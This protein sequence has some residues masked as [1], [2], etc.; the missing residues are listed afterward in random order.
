MQFTAGEI[1]EIVNGELEGDPNVIITGPSKIEEGTAG[2]ISFLANPKYE[3]YIYSSDVAALLVPRD[4][5]PK[6][7]ISATL[8]K[9]KD[10]YGAVAM[11]FEEFQKLNKPF[12]RSKK[13]HISD[14]ASIHDSVSIDA[15][16]FVDSNVT[17][18][19]NTSLYPQVYLGKN[20][21]IGKNCTL[22]PGVKV[23]ANSVIGDNVI[24]HSN[25][26]IGGDG[27]GY[28]RESSGSY[29][30]ITHLGN[31]ILEDFVEVG[32]N[33][34]ID[35]AVLGSTIIH[36]GAK[37]DNL[38]HIAHN[39]EVGEH[40]AMAAQS[41][42]AGSGKIGAYCQIGGQAG[43][44]GHI[45]IP[46]GTLIQAQSGVIKAGKEPKGKLFGSPAIEYGNYLKSYAIFK[47]LPE[48]LIE[49]RNLKNQLKD[50][51]NK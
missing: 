32:A 29:K 24:I 34:T 44:I 25:A 20:V 5:K 42:I 28:S 22:Y 9:V 14:N 41:G 18:K 12:V 26:V 30:K 37:L 23:H 49:I 21:K 4:F 40:S 11:L 16:C 48:L 39:V 50:L 36:K 2:T 27:F 47:K 15:F 13:A 7:I 45:E 31:V 38:I 35:R 6:D 8:I 3:K 51:E 10:V 33:T 17:I 46:E 1:S 43:I 19:E